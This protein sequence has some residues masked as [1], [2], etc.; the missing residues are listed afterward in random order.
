MRAHKLRILSQPLRA[1]CRFVAHVISP[2]QALAIA[3]LGFAGVAAFGITPD[4]SIDAPSVRKIFRTLPMLV[5]YRV[6]IANE[7][8]GG[9]T[10]MLVN[11]IDGTIIKTEKE[12]PR[13]RAQ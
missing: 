11:A 3:V 1:T 9:S 13:K 12:L 8:D 7:G 4:T 5:F 2:G 6:I 10:L